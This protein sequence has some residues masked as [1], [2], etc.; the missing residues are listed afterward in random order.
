MV[1]DESFSFQYLL[2]ESFTNLMRSN[3]NFDA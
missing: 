1:L 2:T 3:E